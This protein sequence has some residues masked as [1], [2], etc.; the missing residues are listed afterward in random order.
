MS[1]TPLRRASS[2]HVRQCFQRADL[3]VHTG[4]RG[5]EARVQP[6][7]PRVVQPWGSPRLRRLAGRSRS[8]GAAGRRSGRRARRD[9]PQSGRPAVP[10]GPARRRAWPGARAPPQ[11][12]RRMHR[13]HDARLAAEPDQTAGCPLQIDGFPL[14]IALAR[15]VHIRHAPFRDASPQARN[16]PAAPAVHRRLL[17]FA[18]VLGGYALRVNTAEWFNIE[19]IPPFRDFYWMIL[20][21]HALRTVDARTPGFLRASAPKAGPAHPG[22][23]RAGAAGA[24]P[25][26]R[27]L[28]HVSEGGRCPRARC[29]SFSWGSPPDCSSP[30]TVSCSAT[31]GGWPS[32]ACCASRCCWPDCRGTWTS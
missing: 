11:A 17:A 5:Q 2:H 24:G 32:A 25:A 22:P 1:Q 18:G 15:A 14:K 20:I 27:P 8:A 7:P 19:P 28:R 31:P 3:H 23:A 4:R 12:F 21:D 29:S 6:P 9:R 30:R 16:Q 10:A 13:R 26:V